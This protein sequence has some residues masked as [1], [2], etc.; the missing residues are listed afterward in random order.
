[1]SKLTLS[2]SS[3]GSTCL[4]TSSTSDYCGSEE[5]S[6]RELEPYV[7]EDGK[8]SD[9][10]FYSLSEDKK[11][12]SQIKT[13]CVTSS[14]SNGWKVEDM[15]QVNKSKYGYKSTFNSEMTEYTL[16]LI[17]Q[18][19]AEFKRRE[20]EAERLAR[21]I[22][23]DLNYR[24]NVDKELSDGEDEEMAFSA[25]HRHTGGDKKQN[26]NTSQSNNKTPKSRRVTSSVNTSSNR[27]Q[28][29][30]PRRS[31]VATK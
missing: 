5:S 31:T 7:F 24:A 25:V 30:Q 21:E 14:S 13:S 22:E 3:S 12:E 2:S 16:P 20:A 8:E 29:N 26:K 9:D 15:L 10:L 6:C 1:M 11:E 28:R 23:S 27:Q 17:K 18:N 19:T 4:S